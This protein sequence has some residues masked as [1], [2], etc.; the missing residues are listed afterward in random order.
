MSGTKSLT[1]MKLEYKWRTPMEWFDGYLSGLDESRLRSAARELANQMSYDDLT[2]I[3]QSDM[4]KDNY[5]TEICTECG[6]EECPGNIVCPQCESDE[7]GLGAE[8]QIEDHGMC[9]DCFENW[10]WRYSE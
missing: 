8:T 3:F 6:E 7:H 2:D 4:G 9:H 1:T 5:W 10:K